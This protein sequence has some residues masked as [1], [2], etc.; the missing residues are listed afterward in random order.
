PDGVVDAEQPAGGRG[1]VYG[2]QPEHGGAVGAGG[3]HVDAPGG[4]VRRGDG[5][6]VRERGAG[7]E[8]G[9]DGAARG[10]DGGAADRGG[11][12]H[13][14]EFRRADRRGADLQP[15]AECGRDPDGH[16]HGG[17]AAG[18]GHAGADG[19]EQ[20]DGHR[21]EWPDQSELD[22]VDGRRGGDGV[23]GGA[24]PGGGVYDVRPARYGAGPDVQ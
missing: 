24:V 5:A 1:D 11:W 23:P 18:G 21:G 6:A 14:G 7:G 19:A 4:D 22:R 16:E 2:G 3:G 17:G 13:G 8:S 9:A 10:H 12:L 15:G 20:S